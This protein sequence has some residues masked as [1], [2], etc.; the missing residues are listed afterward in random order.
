M[1]PKLDPKKTCT[2][3]LVRHGETDW[4]VKHKMQGHQNIPLNK[5]GEK[6]AREAGKR[7]KK[8]KF[9]AVFSSDLSRA[10]RTAEL[11]ALEH[12]LVVKTHQAL[13]ERCFGAY[14]GKTTTQFREELKD[15][16][17]QIKKLPEKEKLAFPMPFNIE[18]QEKAINRFITYLRE[19]AIAYPGKKVLVATHGGPIKYF[20]IKIGYASTKELGWGSI[21]NTAH[22][23]IL[24]D[25][26][27]FFVTDTW[28][29]NKHES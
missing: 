5:N 4:N 21:S 19:I 20:L 8:I 14:E 17:D 1:E 26:I 3:Y 29:V 12:K 24:T 18:T 16:L 11:I 10:K 13:R 27:D 15:L 23:K 7:L 6:Q 22:V 25:G 9:E 28:G 2:I